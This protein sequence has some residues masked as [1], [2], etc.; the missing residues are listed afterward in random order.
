MPRARRAESSRMCLR[1]PVR[2]KRRV[3]VM[4]GS[5]ACWRSARE[6]HTVPTGLSWDPP[7]G[8]AMPVMAKEAEAPSR[9]SEPW[10][11]A[12]ATGAEIAP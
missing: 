9:W 1:S 10:A 3:S 4:S 5:D 6:I 12:E 8:P 11:I 7:E 2:A